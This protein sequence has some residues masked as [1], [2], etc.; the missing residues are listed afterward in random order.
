MKK[1]LFLLFISPLVIQAQNKTDADALLK[2]GLQAAGEG[3]NVQAD[4]LLSQAIE[5]DDRGDFHLQLGMVKSALKDTCS[6]CSEFQM[7]IDKGVN[8]AKARKQEYCTKQDTLEVAEGTSLRKWAD[9]HYLTV[10]LCSDELEHSFSRTID[11]KAYHF[12]L[13]KGIVNG[14]EIDEKTAASIKHN[15][16]IYDDAT[17]LPKDKKTGDNFS[18][19]SL[20]RH[21]FSNLKTPK[22]AKAE[23]VKGTVEVSFVIDIQG[24][25]KDIVIVTSV[26]PRSDKEAIR[27]ISL[28][29]SF[30]P[31]QV[32]GKPV[33]LKFTVPI[34]F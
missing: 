6:A 8:I 20:M 18:N 23:G 5:L 13:K 29:E 14:A 7:A 12:T 32:E 21:L 9:Q 28:L 3:K 4:S 30:T 31:A 1:L 22:D 33:N 17:T 19:L 25:V 16:L 34:S 26:D 11:G 24:Q 27:V 10:H 15:D 2:A